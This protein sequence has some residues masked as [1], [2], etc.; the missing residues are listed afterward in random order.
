MPGYG[1]DNILRKTLVGEANKATVLDIGRP[2]ENMR[3]ML[4]SVVWGYGTG[5]LSGGLLTIEDGN[6]LSGEEGKEIPFTI[7]IA[8]NGPGGQE[9]GWQSAAN[10]DTKAT[11]AA[12]GS[13][14][15]G[16]VTLVYR[17]D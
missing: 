2:G 14:V 3:W 11:L 13:G 6:D 4:L 7:P 5:T 1:R 9:L 10:V 15:V 8:A 16:R 12:G 17:I